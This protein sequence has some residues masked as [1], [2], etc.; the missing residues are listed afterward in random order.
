MLKHD[1][2]HACDVM[3]CR[4]AA[5]GKGF[6]TIND[7]QRHKK[8]VHRIGVDKDSYQCASKNCRNRGKIWPR[9]D[10]FKQ[11][12]SRM[13][14]GEDE[15]DLI[16]RYVCALMVPTFHTDSFKIGLPRGILSLR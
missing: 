4:R 9:L 2:P 7:L 3:G 6:T 15:A 1:K 14:K 16:S 10:N 12:I 11:H 8:S 13:H 5:T